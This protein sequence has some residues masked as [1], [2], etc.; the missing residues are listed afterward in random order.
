MLTPRL[1]AGPSASAAPRRAGRVVPVEDVCDHDQGRPGHRR[2]VH[3]SRPGLSL[4]TV[5]VNAEA[6]V[7]HPRYGRSNAAASALMRRKATRVT[8]MRHHRISTSANAR[9]PRCQAKNSQLHSAFAASWAT[10]RT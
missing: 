9:P 10:N 8:T 4:Q 6:N 2:G 5:K 7:T 1:A 3:E